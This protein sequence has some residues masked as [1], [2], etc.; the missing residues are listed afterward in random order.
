MAAI[1]NTELTFSKNQLIVALV[2]RELIS[3]AV[4]MPSILDAS[5]Y[6]VKGTKSI[7]VPRAGSFAVEDRATTVQAALVG[8]TYAVDTIVLDQMSTVS[9][10]V[11]PQD[12]IEAQIDVQADLAARAAKAHAKNFDTLVIAGLEADSTATTTAGAISKAIFLEMRQLLLSAQADAGQLTFLCGPDSESALLQIGDFVQSYAYGSAI[13]PTGVLGKLYGV[14]VKVSTLVAANRFYMYDKE[15]YGFAIQQALS[16]GE[17][18]APEY[19]SSAVLKVLDMKWGHD[20]LQNG[21]LLYKDN[22]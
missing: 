1:G 21:A 9:W 3:K 4:V 2:Q 18:A 22:N 19:G 12:E 10:V 17:R 8:V 11:D 13:I 7:S 15:G 16:M 6:A 5:V 20:K 14:E